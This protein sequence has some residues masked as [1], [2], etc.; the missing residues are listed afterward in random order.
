MS[1]F[2]AEDAG[3]IPATRSK[4]NLKNNG[5][6]SEAI[7]LLIFTIDWIVIFTAIILVIQSLK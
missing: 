7:K 4:I 5:Y 2:Q 6:K 1:A 3:S